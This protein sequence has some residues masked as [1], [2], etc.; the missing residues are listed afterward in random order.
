MN[1]FCLVIRIMVSERLSEIVP[2]PHAVLTAA[3]PRKFRENI[4]ANTA[5]VAGPALLR[6]ELLN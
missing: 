4:S 1:P 2:P 6:S 5:A 3:E